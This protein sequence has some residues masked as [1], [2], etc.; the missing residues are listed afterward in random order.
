MVR[1]TTKSTVVSDEVKLYIKQV[2]KEMSKTYE[3]KISVLRADFEMKLNRIEAKLMRIEDI[4]IPE[5][6]EEFIRDRMMLVKE[7]EIALQVNSEETEELKKSV[8]RIEQRKYTNESYEEALE[9][10]ESLQLALEKANQ[11]MIEQSQLIQ[12]LEFSTDNVQETL[13]SVLGRHEK[14]DG[15]VCAIDRDL[16]KVEGRMDDHDQYTRRNSLLVHGCKDV[17]KKCSEEKFIQ[18]AVKKLKQLVPTEFE[19][20]PFVIDTAHVLATRRKSHNHTKVII[21]KFKL[22][23]MRNRIVDDYNN[24]YHQFSR[25]MH[26]SEHL[27]NQ[28]MSL[29]KSC[30]AKLGKKN[31]WTEQGVVYGI[32]YGKSHPIKSKQH[33]DTLIST[34]DNQNH[35]N[36]EQE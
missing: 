36:N 27:C 10:L 17:P 31:S 20:S 23:W 7:L 2:Q 12:K 8:E 3:K 13:S 26:I 29:L 33:L 21:I 25:G 1:L 30:E 32:F 22:R 34:S 35:S 28:R 19:I 15:K 18:Y 6:C 11:A 4:S 9:R 24:Y 14:L 16:Y 5:K